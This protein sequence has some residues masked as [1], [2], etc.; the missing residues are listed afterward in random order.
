MSNSERRID[1]PVHGEAHAAFVCKHLCKNPLQEWFCDYPSENNPWPDA[2]CGACERAFQKEGEWN[3]KNENELELTLICNHCYEEIR[4]SSVAPLMARQTERWQRLVSEAVSELEEKQDRLKIQFGI[5]KHERWDYDQ[6][7]GHIVFSNA[8]VPAVTARFQF[9]GSIS[10][11]NETW[12][13]SWANPSVEQR[14]SEAL[15]T[16]R[17]FGEDQKFATLTVPKWP[18]TEE[19]GWEL[20]A[21]AARVLNAEGAYWVPGETGSTFLLLM[22]ISRVQ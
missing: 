12:L 9:V 8:G 1:C 7:T 16:V 5:S 10:S 2:W 19:D 4:G 15:L 6:G 11:V 18:A 20:T 14:I 13:W 17:A 22:E 3:E 21:V